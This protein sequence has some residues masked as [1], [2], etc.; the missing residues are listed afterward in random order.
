MVEKISDFDVSEYLEDEKSIAAY[1]SAI[2][3]EKDTKLL[4]AA[5]GDIAKARGMAKIASDS[6]LGR[7][8]LYKTL[9]P[10]AK[11]RFDTIL[12]VLTSLGVRIEFNAIGEVKKR[13]SAS[14]L[15]VKKNIMKTRHNPPA[16]KRT[17]QPFVAATEH[18]L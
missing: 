1:L 16:G 9:N 13:N 12:K 4:L 2:M 17:K 14:G 15:I 5:I 8:S 10:D 18:F 3:E 11:P 7:E 6:G